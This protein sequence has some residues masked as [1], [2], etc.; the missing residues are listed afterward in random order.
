MP[1]VLSQALPS[2]PAIE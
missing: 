2:P 1:I